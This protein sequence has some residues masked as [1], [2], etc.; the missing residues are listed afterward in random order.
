MPDQQLR[1]IIA[2][3]RRATV[4]HARGC[5]DHFK[6]FTS[7]N[8]ITLVGDHAYGCAPGGLLGFI[9]QQLQFQL[10]V[11]S[12]FALFGQL[13]AVVVIIFARVREKSSWPH[14]YWRAAGQK[15]PVNS[16][17]E[18]EEK[19]KAHGILPLF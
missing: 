10:A 5:V 13:L 16:T 18:R 2:L 9:H 14:R 1:L 12:F 11:R 15:K 8:V 17:R 19:C 4:F 3:S 7:H 6:I